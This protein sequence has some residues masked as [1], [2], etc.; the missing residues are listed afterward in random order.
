MLAVLLKTPT[1][2]VTRKHHYVCVY[3]QLIISPFRSA[4]CLRKPVIPVM[5]K[6]KNCIPKLDIVIAT[7]VGSNRTCVCS[8]NAVYWFWTELR[9][10]S[11]AIDLRLL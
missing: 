10:R 11:Q 7:T 1:Q 8:G 2:E 9:F 6:K 5:S 4:S 3:C